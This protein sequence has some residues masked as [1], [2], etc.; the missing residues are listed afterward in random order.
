MRSLVVALAGNPNC[1][2]TTLFN[3]LT[4][5]HQQVGNW[6]GVTV[7][8]KTGSFVYKDIKIE[9]VDLPGC[10]ALDPPIDAAVDEKIVT[11]YISSKKASVIINVVDANNLQR[12]LYLTLQLLEHDLP[13]I[14]A[15]NM[16][17]VAEKDS[18]VIDIPA[19]AQ[20]LRCP[21]VPLV[22]L[23]EKGINELKEAVLSKACHAF[24]VLSH[25]VDPP[26]PLA[27]EQN[28]MRNSCSKGEG[29]LKSVIATVTSRYETISRL[30]PTVLQR[31]GTSKISLTEK[32]DKWVLDRWIG[33]PIFLVLMYLLFSLTIQV[34]GGLQT[35]WADALHRLLVE[36]VRNG[37]QQF[38]ASNWIVALF[39]LGIGQGIYTTLS[40]IPVIMSMF[41]CLSFLE[42]SG[43]MARAAFVMDK[44]MQGVG[45]SG[46]SFV[47]M[48][49]GFGCNV[50]AILG[51][52]TL[53]NPRERIVTIMMSPFMSCGARL[54]I[55]ALFVT[56]FF[57]RGGQNIIFSL[58]LIGI[59]VAL[60]T[61]WGLRQLLPNDKP[62]PLI[63][64][65]PPYRWPPLKVLLRPTWHRTKRFVLKAGAIIIP[66]C[67]LIGSLGSIK[68]LGQD[69]WL[70]SL[71]VNITHIFAPMGIEKDNW[72]A[73]VGLIAGVL[74]KEVV[75]GTLNALYTQEG[76]QIGMGG[77]DQAVN[78]RTLGIMAERFGGQKNAFAYLLFVLLYFPCV[79]VIATIARELNLSWA[80]FAGT[81]TTLIAYGSAVFF[82]Q[83][84]TFFLHPLSSLG[85]VMGIPVFLIM[86]FW[87]L[88]KW[89]DWKT[90]QK[91]KA[92]PTH[93]VILS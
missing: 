42:A 10:Y 36:D 40:F 44:I 55:Y 80:L 22:A 46:K 19:L 31:T 30:I 13:I 54:A 1:G 33:I 20:A 84:A 45:L 16:M 14:V 74:A 23:S 93:I 32:I 51:T 8:Q 85:W 35:L 29:E 64:E 87:G 48:I 43:Y 88:R 86:G 76:Q 70:T 79:S 71:G 65:L 12:H 3:S 75:V 77:T 67:I 27:A 91:L 90:R 66:V 15:V 52:R 47:P 82:Y 18:L 68:M 60:L 5:G 7:D 59:V 41:F 11:E 25:P 28:N 26:Y 4:G 2:K 49:L 9:L 34:G 37:L 81:W 89:I 56:A 39:S 78:E 61:G 62:M 58:Y 92:F 69:S 21:V 73:T 72:P 38:N 50:P 83:S 57:P 6:A 63:M 53:E 17:D 24:S